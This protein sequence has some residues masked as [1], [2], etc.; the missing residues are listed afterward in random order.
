MSRMSNN[1]VI[2]INFFGIHG[3]YWS[4][5]QIIILASLASRGD[6]NKDKIMARWY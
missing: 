4:C 6:L 2:L 1:F 3:N 5:A